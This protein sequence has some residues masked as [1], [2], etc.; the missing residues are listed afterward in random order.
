MTP[1]APAI[2]GAFGLAR[3]NGGDVMGQF[4]A[5]GIF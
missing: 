5:Y 3:V 4:H 1:N 2:G